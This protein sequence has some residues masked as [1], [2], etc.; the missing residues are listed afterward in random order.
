MEKGTQL[1]NDLIDF[2][3][4]IGTQCCQSKL[5][6]Q[7]VSHNWFIDGHGHNLHDTYGYEQC[8]EVWMLK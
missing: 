3:K 4:V 5:D 7:L 6:T 1:C 2:R 8:V